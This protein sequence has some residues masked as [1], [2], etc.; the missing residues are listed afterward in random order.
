MFLE[1][2]EAVKA[3]FASHR[4]ADAFPRRGWLTPSPPPVIT[5]HARERVGRPR[6]G[7]SP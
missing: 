1:K 7:L 4:E 2:L 3:S 5:K 6:F